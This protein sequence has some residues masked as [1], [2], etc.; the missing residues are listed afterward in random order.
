MK[1]IDLIKKA[2]EDEIK[3]LK[4]VYEYRIKNINFNAKNVAV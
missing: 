1:K 3:N 4:K 2:Y